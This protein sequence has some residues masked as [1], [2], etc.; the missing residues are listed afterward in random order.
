MSLR[1][2]GFGSVGRR[3]AEIAESKGLPVTRYADSKSVVSVSAKEYS[4]K[5][6]IEDKK[7]GKTAKASSPSVTLLDG[8]LSSSTLTTSVVADCSA[9][10][11]SHKI[12]IEALRKGLGVALANKKPLT[13]STEVY[14]EIVSNPRA[15][16]EATV[17]AGLPV[18]CTTKRLLEGG[19]TIVQVQG[20]LSGTLGYILSRLDDPKAGTFSDAVKEAERLG[21]TEPDPRDDL[22]GVDVARKALILARYGLGMPQLQLSDITIEPLFPT[23]FASLPLDEFRRRLPE[24]DKDWSSRIE[25]AK[26]KGK[27]L[28]YTGTVSASG[29]PRVGLVEVDKSSPLG[30]LKGTL[31]LVSFTTKFYTEGRNLVVS[32]PGAGIDVTASGVAADA[33]E[34]MHMK[35]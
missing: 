20:Q 9:S 33:Y 25:K 3:A 4:L 19:D 7:N 27:V 32:G 2:L 6:A 16:W 31:N 30:G 22:G 34:L 12:L 1:I 21:Y 10:D 28:R 18:I 24:L 5:Q 11:S 8:P 35:F 29:K 17:G 14:K 15:R 26:E 13:Q 23:E